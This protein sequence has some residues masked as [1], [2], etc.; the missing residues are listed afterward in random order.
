M[1]ENNVNN[2]PYIVFESTTARMERSIKRLTVALIVAIAVI[3]ASN[4]AWL[5]YESQFDYVSTETESVEVNAD[6][7]SNANYNYIG[8]S[9][10]ITN[11]GEY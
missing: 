11:G 5:I 9:G 7:E 3:F 10:D 2:V 8:E 1:G 6:S 4:I